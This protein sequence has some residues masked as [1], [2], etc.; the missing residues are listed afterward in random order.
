MT[1]RGRWLLGPQR[2]ARNEYAITAVIDGERRNLVIDRTFVDAEGRRWIA[3]YKTS[4]H[5]GADLEAFL[6]SER[7][8]YEKQLARYAI[9]LDEEAELGLYFPL[10]S[11]WRHWKARR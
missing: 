5:E 4:A 9:A 8:R 10:L 11:G 3:D 7:V 6:D 2:E 1:S